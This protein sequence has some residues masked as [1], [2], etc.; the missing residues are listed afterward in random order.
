MRRVRHSG[1]CW[2]SKDEPINSFIYIYI[3]ICVCVCVCVCVYVC[4]CVGILENIEQ[5]ESGRNI[6]EMSLIKLFLTFKYRNH[7]GLDKANFSKE[8]NPFR[9][10]WEEKMRRYECPPL[11]WSNSSN[12]YSIFRLGQIDADAFY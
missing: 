5:L 7:A 10:N 8:L 4:V 9:L 3:Y 6:F 2:R 11:L 12:G 1:H